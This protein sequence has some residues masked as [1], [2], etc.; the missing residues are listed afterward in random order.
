MKGK[1]KNSR[2]DWEKIDLLADKQID[3]SE[4]PELDE[5]FWENAEIVHPRAK[6]KVTIRIKPR[7]LEWFKS[8]GKG[9]QTRI[10]SIL[11]AYI[12]AVQ[13]HK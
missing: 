6:V 1:A 5:L 12:E 11:E 3:Y 7:V 9:Y 13:K 8:R 4:I 2:T 10:N